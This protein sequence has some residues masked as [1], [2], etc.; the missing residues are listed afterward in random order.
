MKQAQQAA[1]AYLKAVADRLRQGEL[2]DLQLSITSSVAMGIDVADTII[3]LAEHGEGAI[4]M[5]V[6]DGFDLIAMATFGRGG[7]QRWIMG[8]VTDRVLGAT[9]LPMLIVRPQRQ[10]AENKHEMHEGGTAGRL[11]SVE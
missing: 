3:R 1:E 4:G 10:R 8:S 6:I 7:V 2:A 9:K 5:N 11:G